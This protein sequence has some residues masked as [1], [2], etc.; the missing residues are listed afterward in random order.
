[1]LRD[2]LGRRRDEV[3]YIRGFPGR[4]RAGIRATRLSS[5]TPASMGGWAEAGDCRHRRPACRPRWAHAGARNVTAVDNP[6]PVITAVKH[7]PTSPRSGDPVTLSVD[8][9]DPDGI[10]EVKLEYQIVDPGAMSA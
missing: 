10:S 5:S 1:M 9:S 4:L 8:L 6:P 2:E 7:Q 3:E